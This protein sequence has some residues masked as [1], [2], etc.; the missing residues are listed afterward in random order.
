MA[1]SPI[2][3]STPGTFVQKKGKIDESINIEGTLTENDKKILQKVSPFINGGNGTKQ[4]N[5]LATIIAL[6]RVHGNLQGEINADYA[7]N[8][9]NR[10]ITGNSDTIPLS[11]LDKLISLVSESRYA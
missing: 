9:K 8:L 1:I 6:D 5:N 10:L 11:I 4:I 2:S 3:Q 7:K